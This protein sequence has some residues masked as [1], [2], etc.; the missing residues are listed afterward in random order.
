M[1]IDP[2]EGIKIANVK[3]HKKQIVPPS[4][5]DIEL[6]LATAKSWIDDPPKVD[7][8]KRDPITPYEDQPGRWRVRYTQSKGA[9]VAKTFRNLA[10]AQKFAET[11]A[12]L[13]NRKRDLV[14]RRAALLGY[15]V[16][17]FLV[18]T[19]ARL[20]EAR[21]APKRDFDA[22]EKTYRIAQRADE[23]GNL[24]VPKSLTSRRT[25]DLGDE[26]VEIL[27]EL[28]EINADCDLLFPS[29]D[30][31][32]FA[33]SNFYKRYWIPLLIACNLAEAFS[34]EEAGDDGVVTKFGIH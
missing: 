34:G 15:G 24:G 19:G 28:S 22:E 26:L 14:T 33:A 16:V 8:K 21:G 23:N 25:I 4:H 32:P 27:K 13:Q 7:E 12:S 1:A 30:G 5:A 20:S 11:M 6:L 17:K 18:K 3:R 2:C 29:A 10:D 9:R 31:T